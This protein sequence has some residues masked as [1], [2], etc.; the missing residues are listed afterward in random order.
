VIPPDAYVV[1]VQRCCY[2]GT[3]ERNDGRIVAKGNKVVNLVET[4]TG[5]AGECSFNFGARGELDLQEVRG[6]LLEVGSLTLP[7]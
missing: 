3:D 7:A 6:H 1:G 4:K 2:T 5:L